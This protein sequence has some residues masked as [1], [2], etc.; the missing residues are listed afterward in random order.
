[1]YIYLTADCPYLDVWSAETLTRHH[2]A[3]V[4]VRTARVTVARLAAERVRL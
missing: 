1:M 2:V 3:L 4:V